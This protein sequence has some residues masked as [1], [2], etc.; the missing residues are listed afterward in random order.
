MK[1]VCCCIVGGGLVGMM[2]GYFF[3]CVGIEVVVLEKYVDFFCDFCG[4]IVYFLMM[5]ILFEFG[6]FD[7]FLVWL[8]YWFDG[9]EILWNGELLWIGDFLYFNMFVLFIV[10]ML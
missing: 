5:D 2:L 4:D 6:L 9:V 7:C 10:M 3:G 1:K 8:Y